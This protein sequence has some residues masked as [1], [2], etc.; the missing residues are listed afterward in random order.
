M[1]E[2]RE[3]D[4]IADM[5]SILRVKMLV[6][7]TGLSVSL[8]VSG[9]AA[10][11]VPG[12]LYAPGMSVTRVGTLPLIQVPDNVLVY[13]TQF[14]AFEDRAEKLADAD[15]EMQLTNIL[16]QAQTALS[17]FGSGLPRCVRMNVCLP[18]DEDRVAIQAL[19]QRHL[20]GLNTTLTFVSGKL[21]NPNARAAIDLVAMTNIKREHLAQML[22]LA[23]KSAV[24]NRGALTKWML[25]GTRVFVSGQAVRGGNVAEAARKTLEQLGRTL[26]QLG[27]ARTNVVQVKSFLT[28]ATEAEVVSKE[29]AGWFGTNQAP[30]QVFVEWLSRNPIEIELVVNGGPAREKGAA[31]EFLTPAGMKPSPVFTRVVRVNRGSLVFTSS[32]TGPTDRGTENEIRQIFDELAFSMKVFGSDMKHLAKATYYVKSPESSKALN[33]LRP[34]FYD[35]KRP[36][37]ASK[38]MVKGVGLPGHSISID[39]IGVVE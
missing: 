31:V 9:R 23:P 20:P 24:G 14:I 11:P 35:P 12:A 28:P 32:L 3:C 5:A 27:L 34:E 4:R 30:P 29:I 25:P 21:T 38:A 22:Q 13:T 7:L 33:V 36:P 2:N 26:E 16:Y 8:A 19:L 18:R 39:M 10:A 17:N 37:A 6:A 15:L 1:E